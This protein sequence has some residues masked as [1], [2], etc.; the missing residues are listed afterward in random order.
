MII[1]GA[2]HRA[3]FFRTTDA[4]GEEISIWPA[5]AREVLERRWRRVLRCEGI[6]S[7]ARQRAERLLPVP[8][9]EGLRESCVPW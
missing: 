2:L 7:G 5:Q 4:Q 1:E 3:W 8:P 9:V 6:S